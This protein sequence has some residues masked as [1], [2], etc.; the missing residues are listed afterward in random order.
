M[1][2][3]SRA[4]KLALCAAALLMT[5]QAQA[6]K[7][8]L[9]ETIETSSSLISMPTT[10]DGLMTVTPTCGNCPTKV[11]RS[12]AS[13]VFKLRDVPVS[14]TV[15]R[16]ALANSDTYVAVQFIQSTN[17]LVSVTA[18]IEPPAARKP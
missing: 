17:D 7:V 16:Q 10:A 15:F 2:V 13:T 14:F 3:L 8:V 11:F 12:T 1:E 18:N 5:F 6:Q 9:K 4:G